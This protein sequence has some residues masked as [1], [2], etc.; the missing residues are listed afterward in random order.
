MTIDKKEVIT[1]PKWLVIV[2]VPLTLGLIGGY[3]SSK[4]MAGKRDADITHLQQQVQ[5]KVDRNE[6]QMIQEALTRIESKLDKHIDK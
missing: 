4:F 1:I 3:S 6:I 5:N 2:M